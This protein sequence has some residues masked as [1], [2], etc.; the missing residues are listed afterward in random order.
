MQTGYAAS[1]DKPFTL[2]SEY[3]RVITLEI[4]GIK[5]GNAPSGPVGDTKTQIGFML[6][7]LSDLEKA[8]I[9]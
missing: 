6:P 5:L 9:K 7:I 4:G 2:C 8:E 1:L 3:D